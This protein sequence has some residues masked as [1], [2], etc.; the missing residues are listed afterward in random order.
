MTDRKSLEHIADLAGNAPLAHP[1]TATPLSPDVRSGA[2]FPFKGRGNAADGISPYLVIWVY[3]VSIDCRRQ[4]ADA[5]VDYEDTF[6]EDPA[7]VR[8]GLV[9]RGT[10]SVSISSAAPDYEYRTIWSLD[11]LKNLETLN[12]A[13]ADSANGKLQAM[14]KLIELKPPMRAEIMGLTK[15]TMRA[16]S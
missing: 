3:S 5:V 12:E 6:K 11:S 1:P 16:V 14:L 15:F 8:P 9:Y 2:T 13:I 10:F 4:F 7:I